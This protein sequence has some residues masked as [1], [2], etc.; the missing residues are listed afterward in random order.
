MVKKFYLVLLMVIIMSSFT[1]GNVNAAQTKNESN[2]AVQGMIKENGTPIKNSLVLIGEVGKKNW[3]HVVTDANGSFKAKLSD[4]DYVI[5]SVKEKNKSWYSANEKFTVNDSKIKGLK[6]GEINLSE[7]KQLK[8]SLKQDINLKGVLKEGNKG[9]K[10]DLVIS[11]YGEN[12]EGTYTVASKGNGSFSASLS[13]GNY[14]IV[15]IEVDGGFYRYEKRFT[16]ADGKVLVDGEPK[17]N[18]SINIPVNK[19]AGIVKDSAS[20]LSE[21]TI[22]LEK[23]L[24]NEEYETELIET[25]VTNKKGEFSLRELADGEYEISVYHETY[26][27]WKKE[28][29]K[30]V[31]GTVYVNGFDASVI[32][33]V[34][35]DINLKGTL[36]DDIQPIT[37]ANVNFEGETAEGEYVG[38]GT[39]VDSE[40]N[41]Q[42]RLQD[43]KYKV[44]S[45]DEKSRST[46]VN[47][48]FE[49]RDG[50][51]IQNGESSALN[52]HLPSVTFNGKLLEESGN[53]L[54]GGVYV[55][56][57]SEEGSTESYHAY[58]DETGIYSLRLKDGTYRVTGG[59]LNGEGEDLAFSTMFEI[60]NGKLFVDG[61]E[62]SLLELKL[63]AVSVQGLVQD[64]DTPAS[65]GYISVSSEDGTFYTWESLNPDGTF[66][67]RLADGS[68]RI[69]DIQLEDGT[70]A[71]IN[72]SFSIQ[73]GKT[74]VNGQLQEVLKITVPP[75]TLTG[76]ITDSGNPISG[77][78]YIMEMNDADSP[79]E[80]RASAN[81]EGKFHLRLPDGEY[82]V[83]TVY[84]HDGTTFSSGKEFSI[85]SGQ[86]YENGELSQ[87]LNIAVDPVTVTGTVKNGEE[88]VAEGSL[89]I[90]SIDGNWIAGNPSLIQNGFYQ[91][92][93]PDG[94]YLISMVEDYQQGIF[95]FD[96]KFSI[97]EGKMIVDGQE[98]N[99]LDINLQDG[100]Q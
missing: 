5:K 93:L 84:L 64:G 86:L 69:N 85:V 67:M 36:Q 81:E 53:A 47:S 30:V 83:Y 28:N 7:T 63:P 56:R 50:K 17:N 6:K 78:I 15:G 73:D 44:V 45:I 25:V 42:Y 32:E 49:I 11:K 26:V 4:G 43:G 13:D 37:D 70:N 92:R 8:K 24:L 66:K 21:A 95:N 34:V 82:K 97:I 16:V 52:I 99:S 72:Q 94:E 62:Q 14:M 35:P 100:W 55:E 76:T 27:A 98:V 38:F 88:P 23:R 2:E 68:Y 40:G 10:A 12:E 51:L 22:V 91:K 89:Y 29:F 75:I 60:I 77:D 74:Y 31:E 87:Q 48:P 1:I 80:A 71:S 19:H 65:N 90:N 18:L 54:Q 41:F 39:P 79:L 57:V 96:K 3:N 9:L 58:T 46:L 33:I 59:H 20:S 61:Q